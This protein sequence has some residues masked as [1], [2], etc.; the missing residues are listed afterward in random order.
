MGCSAGP[1]VFPGSASD[2]EGLGHAVVVALNEGD[3]ETLDS[4][5]LSETEHNE[6]VWPELP[7]A[8]SENPYTLEFA[9][10]NIQL[11]NE[12][13][14]GRLAHDLAPLIPMAYEGIE[15]RGVTQVFDTFQVRTDCYVR[16]SSNGGLYEVQFFKDVLERGGGHKIFR[17]YDE[18]PR[19]VAGVD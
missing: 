18:S 11:R 10:Q 4:F 17:Y 7:A 1:S 6:V 9:W 14:L 3:Q 2:L 16:F 19:K 5:R 8:Q 12:R 15:C 13:A